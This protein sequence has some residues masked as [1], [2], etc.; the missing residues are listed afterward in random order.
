VWIAR[1]LLPA[2]GGQQQP[3][4]VVSL[5]LKRRLMP[6]LIDHLGQQV[7]FTEQRWRARR[8]RAQA[9]TVGVDRARVRACGREPK[10]HGGRVGQC[11]QTGVGASSPNV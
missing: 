6:L 10:L 11:R 1:L 3:F 2:A 5:R 7:R 8:C 4:A 9:F